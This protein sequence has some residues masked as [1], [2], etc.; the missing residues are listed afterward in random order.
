MDKQHFTSTIAGMVT[1]TYAWITH[2][3]LHALTL[4]L[5]T[6]VLTGSASFLGSYITKQIIKKWKS[7]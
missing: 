6:A 4:A 3:T 2:S 5:I 1:G 7:K